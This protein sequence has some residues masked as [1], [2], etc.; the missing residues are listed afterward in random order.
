MEELKEDILATFV[1]GIC[2]L[3]SLAHTVFDP[4]GRNL[5]KCALLIWRKL[6][7]TYKNQR[8]PGLTQPGYVC[9]ALTIFCTSGESWDAQTWVGLLSAV[10]EVQRLKNNRFFQ[11]CTLMIVSACLCAKPVDTMTILNQLSASEAYLRFW[12]SSSQGEPGLLLKE[13][14]LLA[15]LSLL[16][17][18]T[19]SSQW[20]QLIM[21]DLFGRVSLYQKELSQFEQ[22]CSNDINLP[23]EFDDS[24]SLAQESPPPNSAKDPLDTYFNFAHIHSLVPQ[25]LT[26]TLLSKLSSIPVHPSVPN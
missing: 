5:P 11:S 3:G 25:S 1:K 18:P 21:S 14:S 13:L 10:F 23:A 9:L 2:L 7:N 16:E 12:L 4:F 26:Q 8:D 20:T 24:Q 22:G 17:N 6:L 15:R 19:I